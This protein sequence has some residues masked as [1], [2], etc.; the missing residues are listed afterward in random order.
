MDAD[1]A[2]EFPVRKWESSEFMMAATRHNSTVSETIQKTFTSTFNIMSVLFILYLVSSTIIFTVYQ[3]IC[4][5]TVSML[6]ILHRAL[7]VC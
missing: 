2:W 5:N 6:G 3:S 7:I 4:W 1:Y